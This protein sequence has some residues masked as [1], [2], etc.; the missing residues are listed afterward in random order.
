M[1]DSYI[2]QAQAFIRDRGEHVVN[3][4]D[5][6][7]YINRARREI[8][9]RTQCIRILT[10]IGGSV[11][12]ITVTAAGTGY[13]AP[14]VT[15]SAPDAPNGALPLPNG[16]QATAAAQLVGGQIAG[17]SVTNGGAGYFNPSAT[18]T[19]PHGTGATATVQV[20][21]I[22][23]TQQGQEVYRFA[24]AALAQF[25]GVGSIFNV[26][27]VS[28]I[29]A[30]YRYSLPCYPFSVYQARI[31]Q[32]PVLYQYVPTMCAQ[33]GQG[34]N[35]SIYFYPIPS[36]L[37]QMEWDCF[38]LPVDLTDDADAEAIPAPWTDNVPYFAA[39]LAFLEMQ[40]LNAAKFYFEL[41]DQMVHRYSA[42]TRPGRI[43]N[44]YGKF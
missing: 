7:T 13:T 35:G 21:P 31:R 17:I 34:A 3:P 16:L 40:N 14:V 8:A 19:D 33:Y 22:N 20:S 10:P 5:L 18:I 38:C 2:Q 28:F 37:Y 23:I 32:Y 26:H 1:L 15:L 43:T 29:Y 24:D 9:L 41:H 27:S 12:T 36:N 6:R 25:P 11:M 30:N 4:A 39:H 42:W 44:P